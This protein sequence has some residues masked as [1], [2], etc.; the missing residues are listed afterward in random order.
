VTI[1]FTDDRVLEFRDRFSKMSDAKPTALASAS[2]ESGDVYAP[3][4]EL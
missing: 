1:E 2:F 4:S 3:A